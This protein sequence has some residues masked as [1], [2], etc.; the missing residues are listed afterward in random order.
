[1]STQP[2]SEEPV[3]QA[4]RYRWP[5]LTWVGLAALAVGLSLLYFGGSDEVTAV[6]VKSTGIAIPNIMS[7]PDF[8]VELVLK[9]GTAQDT[10]SYTDTPIGGGLTFDL[11]AP[12]SLSDISQVVLYDDDLLRD[13]MLDRADVA[14]RNCDGQSHGF[15]LMGPPNRFATVG[16]VV[17]ACGAICLAYVAIAFVRAHAL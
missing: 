14:G 8:Y 13:E 1:M 2:A 12:V 10:A 4:H 9:D 6:R 17:L 15:E 7:S 3:P 5:K 16:A 11:P